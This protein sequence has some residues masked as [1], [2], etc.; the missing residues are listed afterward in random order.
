MA[1]EACGYQQIHQLLDNYFEGLYLADSAQLSKVFHDNAQ[2]V[3]ATAGQYLC[4]NKAQYMA[5]INNRVS[6]ESRGDARYSKVLQIMF[7]GGALAHVTLT[8]DML[9]NRYLDYLTLVLHE[10]RWQIIAKVFE[11]TGSASSG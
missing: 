3:N 2:Y 11:I 9:G 10:N 4:L 7:S 5:V 1:N 6:P 8:M